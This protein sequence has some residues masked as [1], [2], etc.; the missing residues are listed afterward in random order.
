MNLAQLVNNIS[1]EI[2]L[3]P[4]EKFK[5]TAHV[6]RFVHQEKAKI[7]E[8]WAHYTKSNGSNGR[9]SDPWMHKVL[10]EALV[11][12]E[13][14]MELPDDQL[15]TWSVGSHVFKQSRFFSAMNRV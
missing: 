14:L 10:K 1:K 4:E 5:L 11:M 13:T 7:Y 3:T 15:V 9:S 12:H 8:K 2:D 6:K